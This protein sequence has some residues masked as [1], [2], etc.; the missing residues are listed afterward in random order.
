MQNQDV[1]DTVDHQVHPLALDQG[2]GAF[3]TQRVRERAGRV[4]VRDA[5]PPVEVPFAGPTSREPTRHA[6]AVAPGHDAECPEAHD[7]QVV[8]VVVRTPG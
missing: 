5:D 3:D 2:D 8:S 4:G 6:A 7:P 1:F